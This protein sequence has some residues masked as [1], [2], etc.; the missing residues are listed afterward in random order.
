MT[1]EGLDIQ[2]ILTNREMVYFKKLD[3]LRF[4]T[5]NYVTTGTQELSGT[6]LISL[7]TQVSEREMREI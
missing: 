1:P 5:T 3:F 4:S 6:R 2:K 7:P